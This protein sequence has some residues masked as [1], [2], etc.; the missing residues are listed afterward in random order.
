MRVVFGEGEM[1]LQCK[2]LFCG[3]RRQERRALGLTLIVPTLLAVVSLALLTGC[4]AS[5]AAP[6]PAPAVRVSLANIDFG[7]WR[8]NTTSS[9]QNLTV[10]NS[11][12][13]TL[14]ISGIT[15]G[16]TS[17]AAFTLTNGCGGSLSPGSSCT[18]QVTFSPSSTTSMSASLS[19]A[20]DAAN[21]PQ[22]IG[23]SGSGSSVSG[24][25]HG[26]FMFDPPINDN[27][28]NSPLPSTCYSQHLVPTFICTGAGTPAGYGCSQPGPGE[29]YVDG[30]VFQVEWGR[31]NPSNGN[32][33]FSSSDSKM[34]AWTDSGKLVSF[35]FEPAAFGSTNNAT[36]SW[37]LNPVPISSVSQSG[38]IIKVQSSEGFGF[39][40]GAIGSAAN[41]HLEI[42]ITGTGTPLDTTSTNPGIYE[43][44]DSSTQGC[45]NPS[46]Q[47]IYAIGP[48]GDTAAVSA[49]SVGNPVY[50]SACTSGILPIE[51]RP[52]FIMAWR[53]LI[54]Q[55]V[56]HYG[57]NN[58]V[59]Y[60][61]FGMGIGGQTEPTNGLS[62]FDTNQTACQAQLTEFGFTSTPAPWPNPGTSGWAQVSNTW[63]QYLA[64]MLLY[65]QSLNSQHAIIIT[66]SPII[67][68]PD[69][70]AT[71]NTTA[72]NA[73]ASGIG[74]GDQ[75]LSKNDPINYAEGNTCSGGNWCANFPMYV[76]EVPTEQQTLSDSDPT[77]QSQ[78]G[79]LAPSLLTF[80]TSHGTDI[81]ELYFDDW[82][83][84]YDNSWSGVNTYSACNTAGYP[85]VFAAAAA[86]IN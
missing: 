44:C 24:V 82:M 86:Q 18:V 39:L 20:D 16:G 81:L 70:V 53:A 57:S 51:W 15:L 37:Y 72:A 83:C 13:A 55:A 49:G 4:G 5:A 76:G 50:G 63:V 66:L 1:L 25:A 10:R 65:E 75:G 54:A 46:P 41:S 3:P 23:L 7:A 47:T 30:A 52:N 38:G 28:C 26:M 6:P 60:M 36:P 35:V 84:T 17:A 68:S 21:S 58:S 71:S 67:F 22:T 42:Q 9:T 74:I 45:Q 56:Q 11:G 27:N 12:N 85:A 19:I 77:N 59:A 32:Y 43:I 2:D 29:P 8:V 48:G 62:S 40:P 33:D 80:A 14:T 69:D 64:N 79:S 61:R 34:Q 78:M 31:L 73:A